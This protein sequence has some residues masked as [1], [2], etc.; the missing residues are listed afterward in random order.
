MK[1]EHFSF[2][3]SNY[4]PSHEELIMKAEENNNK[5]TI[6]NTFDVSSAIEYKR[7][8]KIKTEIQ[9]LAAEVDFFIELAKKCRI[10]DSLITK[11]ETYTLELEQLFLAQG[12]DAYTTLDYKKLKLKLDNYLEVYHQIDAELRGK[13]DLDEEDTPEQLEK[14]ANH[15]LK[16][17]QSLEALLD[18]INSELN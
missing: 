9:N 10:H 5:E 1:F 4:D 18:P 13:Y 3:K 11:I 7:Y 12:E 17:I 15:F 16:K 2:G 6:D 8:E 14:I